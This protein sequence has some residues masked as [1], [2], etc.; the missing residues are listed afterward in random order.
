M[1][2]LPA[3]TD[4]RRRNPKCDIHSRQSFIAQTRTPSQNTPREATLCQTSFRIVPVT[5]FVLAGSTPMLS[6]R[7]RR[8][9]RYLRHTFLVA[10]AA[11][12]ARQR[13]ACALLFESAPSDTGVVLLLSN[14]QQCCAPK[15]DFASQR[16]D[17]PAN[18]SNICSMLQRCHNNHHDNTH[19]RHP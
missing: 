3:A 14:A 2:N 5:P 19:G 7:L 16:E 11:D 13:F 12:H 17:C 10:R 4:V 15:L 6:P 8:C 9:Q 1:C 18:L